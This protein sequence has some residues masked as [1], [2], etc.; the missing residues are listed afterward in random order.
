MVD[1]R[2]SVPGSGDSPLLTP[3]L[4]ATQPLIVGRVLVEALG[5]YRVHQIVL[6]PVSHCAEAL[7]LGLHPGGGRGR[8]CASVGTAE[9][10]KAR[11]A[12]QADRRGGG[13]P[14]QPG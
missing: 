12:V 1:E 4:L 11:A 8:R 3:C 10:L 14:H 6:A 9:L 5:S 2:S 7:G 13:A